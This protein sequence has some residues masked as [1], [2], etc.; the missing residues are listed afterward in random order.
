M[1]HGFMVDR[2]SLPDGVTE[3][4]VSLFDGSNCGIRAPSRRA[5]SVQFHPEASPGPHDSVDLFTQFTGMMRE[6][7]LTAQVTGQLR[8]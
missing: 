5:F 2:D 4:H 8:S 7:R 1:N 3:T 6:R